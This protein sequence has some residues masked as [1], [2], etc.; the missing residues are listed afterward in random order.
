MNPDISAKEFL[1]NLQGYFERHENER[2]ER[3]A[4]PLAEPSIGFSA[5]CG[6]SGGFDWDNGILFLHPQQ[7]L[8]RAVRLTSDDLLAQSKKLADFYEKNGGFAHRKKDV[9]DDGFKEGARWGSRKLFE[10]NKGLT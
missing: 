1:T 2:W 6:L 3:V 5:I 9:W 4:I 10:E 7:S 8:I